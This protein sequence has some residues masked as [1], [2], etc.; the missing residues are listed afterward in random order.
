MMWL[1]KMT[2]SSTF[3]A[4]LLKIIHPDLFTMALH[5]MQKLA[6]EPE[7]EPFITAWSNLFN[8]V[9]IICNRETPIHRDTN[10][11]EH[12]Y[13]FLFTMGPYV[14]GVMEIPGVGIRLAYDSGT[15]VALTGRVL[16]HGVAKV[17]GD[18]LCVAYYMRE[19]VQRRMAESLALWNRVDNYIG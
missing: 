4:A 2:D 7:L 17:D 9:S 15:M 16:R 8:G 1:R 19:N 13:D 5:T 10:S 18:R 3:T 12:W 14:D 11:L 6:L